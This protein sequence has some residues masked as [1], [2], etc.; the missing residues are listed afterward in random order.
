M[1]EGWDRAA[2]VELIERQHSELWGRGDLSLIEECYAD[3]FVGHFPGRVVRGHQ[4]I[5]SEVVGHRT[6]FPDWQEEV[7]RVIVEGGTVVSHFRSGG[8][9]RGGFSGSP[10]TGKRVDITEVAVFRVQGVK[11]V[12]QWVYPDIIALQ[13]QLGPGETGR[14]AP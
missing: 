7:L 14:P 10:P 5:R 3:D 6:T 2:L 9:D 4:G 11:I 8:T 13:R 1:S 12:E